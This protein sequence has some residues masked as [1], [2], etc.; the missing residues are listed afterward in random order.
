MGLEL[1]S[2]NEI[3]ET[4]TIKAKTIMLSISPEITDV[5]GLLGT[6]PTIL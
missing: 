6:K 4:P 3:I 1:F 5:K 2:G